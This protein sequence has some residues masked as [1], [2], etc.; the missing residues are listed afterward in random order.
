MEPLPLW[1]CAGAVEGAIEAAAAARSVPVGGGDW[2]TA[3][4]QLLMSPAWLALA[5]AI[6]L[7]FLDVEL[8]TMVCHSDAL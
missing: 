1:Q 7:S 8:P 4:Q 6:G 2:A 3:L 5:A